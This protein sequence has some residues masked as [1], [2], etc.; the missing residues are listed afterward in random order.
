MFKA[1]Q[2]RA[3][4]LHCSA[5]KP[6]WLCLSATAQNPWSGDRG[7]RCTGTCEALQ[8]MP[9]MLQFREEK[10][11]DPVVCCNHCG[12]MWLVHLWIPHAAL[13]Q[14]DMTQSSEDVYKEPRP[15]TGLPVRFLCWVFLNRGE[16]AVLRVPY[17][18]RPKSQCKHESMPV[19]GRRKRSCLDSRI[20]SSQCS[21]LSF[22]LKDYGGRG[23]NTC[24]VHGPMQSFIGPVPLSQRGAGISSFDSLR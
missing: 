2:D 10:S 3:L 17:G 19:E 24:F 9:R 21:S 6:V 22:S 16:P 5:P 20:L 4:A 13:P 1:M 12:W 18:S 7:S 14:V 11:M 8:S 23:T 15:E